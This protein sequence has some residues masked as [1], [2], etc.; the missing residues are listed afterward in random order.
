MVLEFNKVARDRESGMCTAWIRLPIVYG[1]RD[2]LSVPVILA[3]L[4]EGQTNYQL[5]DGTNLWDFVSADN[6]ARWLMFC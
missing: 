1:E 4:E 3:L 2:L 5:G 6:A